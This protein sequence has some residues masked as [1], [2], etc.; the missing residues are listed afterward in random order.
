MTLPILIAALSATAPTSA[1][2]PLLEEWKTPFGLPP[3]QEIRPEHYLPALQ[4]AMAAEKREVEAIAANPDPPTFANTIEALEASGEPLGRV[5]A[6][7][8]NLVG[9]ETSEKLQAVNREATP[10]LS[11]HRDSI[12]L[13]PGLW[14]RVKAVWEARDGLSLAVDQRMLLERTGKRFMRGGAELDGPAK[15]RLKAVNAELA[16]LGIRFGDNLLAEMNAFR[17]VLERPEQLAGLSSR[18]IEAAAEAARKAAL[19]GKWVFTLHQPSYEA[20][21]QQ[22]SDRALRRKL[23]EAYTTRGDH[24]DVRD[25]KRILART[26]ALRVEKAR[27]FGF[28][29]WADY[30]LDDQMART[31]AQVYALVDQLWGPAKAAAAREAQALAEAIRA[32]G[33]SHPVEPWDWAYYT[34]KVRKARYDLDE[35]ELRPYFKLDNV[36]EGAFWLA[37]RLYGISFTELHDVPIYHPEVKAFEVKDADGSHL[38]VYLVDDHPRPGK[39]GGAWMSGWRGQWVKNGVPVRPLVVNV[40]NFSRPVGDAPALLSLQETRTLFHEFGHA[41]HSILGK[42]RY[43]SLGNVP[44]DFVELPSQVMENWAAEPEVMKAYARHWQTGAPIPEALVEK[45]RRS[46][47]F[48]QGFASTEYLAATLLDLEWHTL[49]VPAEADAAALERIALSR[50]AMP[51]TI[52][53]RYRSTYFQHVFGPGGG[54]SAGY[55][56]Y[57]W[58]NV[59]DADA[60][61]A[62]QEKGLFDQ[63]TAR[64][65]RENVLEKGRS[66]DPMEL[67]VRFRGRQPSVEPLL[68]RLGFN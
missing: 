3:W 65:F 2:N 29:T 10:L 64:A 19:P 68:R 21:L 62:F 6:V 59:L 50:M 11:A 49:V 32:D 42:R 15:E 9:A 34:E 67:Y 33:Q 4:E 46:Q 17:L 40:C 30:V 39:R 27:L 7:L 51:A 66:E 13:H 48:N 35:G 44:R 14:K 28:A 53:P 1:G 56:S 61:S 22:S 26:A 57:V 5:T 23:F 43:Q 60:F 31:P 55:Y 54:Y 18:A 63:A 52:V 16:S 45:I 25:N 37:N 36:R 20:F 47:R 8:Q 12:A 38:A 58:A 24:G 41:L